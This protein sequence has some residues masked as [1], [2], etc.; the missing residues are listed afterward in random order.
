LKRKEK[1][2][3]GETKKAEDKKAFQKKRKLIVISNFIKEEE[4]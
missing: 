3:K 2:K 1:R 4:K